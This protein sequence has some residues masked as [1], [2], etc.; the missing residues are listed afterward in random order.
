[1][2]LECD[3]MRAAA[4]VFWLMSRILE[5]LGSLLAVRG[6]SKDYAIFQSIQNARVQ[7]EERTLGGVGNVEGTGRNGLSSS[8]RAI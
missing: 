7:V 4:P 8:L 1:M 5:L 6:E 3:L 2:G